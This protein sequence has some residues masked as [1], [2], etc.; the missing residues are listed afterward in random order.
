MVKMLPWRLTV[1]LIGS[2][3]YLSVYDRQT[4]EQRN[5]IAL[6]AS[7]IFGSTPYE[8]YRDGTT[9]HFVVREG[10]EDGIDKLR[11]LISSLPYLDEDDI[12]DAKDDVPD[13][14]LEELDEP[15]ETFEIKK[16][17]IPDGEYAGMTVN[18]AFSAYGLF[19]LSRI[20]RDRKIIGSDAYRAAVLFT[21]SYFQEIMD[22]MSPE[23][24]SLADFVEA[25]APFVKKSLE[26]RHVDKD[27]IGTLGAKEGYRLY[28][29]LLSEVSARMMASIVPN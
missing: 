28:Y 21:D 15:P 8:L 26:K 20:L 27:T 25:F 16:V 9:V 12:A 6:H 13:Q 19:A 23:Y 29:D 10:S 11:L 1:R 22:D 14:G 2:D 18:E 5:F 24:P 3:V 4:K 17:V 7:H